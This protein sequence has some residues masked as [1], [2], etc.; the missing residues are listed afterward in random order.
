MKIRTKITDRQTLVEFLKQYT[1]QKAIYL[2]AP[3]FQYAVGPYTV[4]RNANIQADPSS[5]EKILKSLQEL[6][7]VDME[8]EDGLRVPIDPES[9]KA[10]MNLLNMV[11][12][13]GK[14]ISKAI[15]KEGALI[16]TR[17]FLQ[18][19]QQSNPEDVT[20]F[21]E[22]MALYQAGKGLHGLKFY[23]DK[24]IFTCFQ[25]DGTPVGNA[26]VALARAMVHAAE[27]QRWVKPEPEPTKNEKYTFR[28]WLTSIGMK[29]KQ[30]SDARTVLLYNLEGNGSYRTEEQYQTAMAKL[31]TA[32]KERR[33]HADFTI[34]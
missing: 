23:R 3:G 12:S 20:A 19:M 26:C 6:G 18:Q 28:V 16:I 10:R 14:L 31:A 13:R 5:A 30:Y 17:S 4:L 9:V 27:S 21:D 24:V 22:A 32:R 2:G 11:S 7:F 25:D 34:L 15:G 1:G 33:P 29:G 8:E